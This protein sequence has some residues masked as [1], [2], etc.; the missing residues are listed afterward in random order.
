MGYAFGRTGELRL[1]YEGGYQ[2][3]S[4]QIGNE[5]ELPTVSGATGD[6]TLLH[7]NGEDVKVVQELL[8]HAL[9]KITLDTYRQSRPPS[10]RHRG[11]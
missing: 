3:L 11:R 10:A 7:A 6:A 2:H 9:A 8:R 1:G 4:P 5:A